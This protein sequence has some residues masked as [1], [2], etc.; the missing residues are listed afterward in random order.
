[1]FALVSGVL[2]RAPATRTSKSGRPFTT[3]TLKTSD[4]DAAKFV[5]VTA[6]SDTVREDLEGLGD[7]DA[8]SVT[9]KLEAELYQPDGAAPRVSLSIV[10]DKV[11]VLKKPERTKKPVADSPA[12][13]P[14]PNLSQ[15]FNALDDDLPF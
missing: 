3:A 8:L 12:A 10:A 9:G 14:T 5:R 15:R 13:K 4:G 7:G 2:F 6:F 11:L 1:M